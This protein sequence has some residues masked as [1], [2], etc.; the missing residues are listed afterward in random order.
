M[1]E[2]SGN[3]EEIE[4]EVNTLTIG[5]I[6]KKDWNDLI[7]E[8]NE[9]RRSNEETIEQVS[10]AKTFAEGLNEE[11]R[12]NALKHN[13]AVRARK[14]FFNKATEKGSIEKMRKW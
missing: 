7:D 2:N 6:E 13:L 1:K 12:E 14:G 9:S 8:E 4:F 10:K 5:G 11:L 3:V